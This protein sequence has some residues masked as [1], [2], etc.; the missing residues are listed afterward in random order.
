M[1]NP[2]VCS[3]K[4]IWGS[5]GTRDGAGGAAATEFAGG[6]SVSRWRLTP[7]AKGAS[8]KRGVRATWTRVC[9]GLSGSA[10]CSPRRG[11][12]RAAV[13]RRRRRPGHL[14]RDTAYNT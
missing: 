10:G 8:G 9:A 7:S 6:L 12:A 5:V 4:R 13:E 2:L 11:Y 14:E 1:G 3:G